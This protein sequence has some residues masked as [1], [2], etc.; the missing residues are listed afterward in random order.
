M[1]ARDR[2][3]RV[4]V[5]SLSDA[6]LLMLILGTGFPGK[7]AR[8]VAEGLLSGCGGLKSLCQHYPQ[9]LCRVEGIGRARAAQVLAALELSKRA[10]QQVDRRPRLKSPEEI[11][12]HL[13]PSMSVLRKEVFH[14][15]CFNARQVLLQDARVAEGTLNACPVDPREVF[16]AALA[17][18]ASGIVL[19]HNHPSGDPEPS[20]LDLALTR[21]LV[22]GGQI[23][24]IRVLDHLIL[25]D[26]AFTS[27]LAR[28]QLPRPLSQPLLG[29]TARPLTRREESG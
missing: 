7:S 16:S 3:Y 11:Y 17:A 8:Q 2:L 4:G 6:E 19:A 28:G 12:R 26:G 10:H 20:I 18:H 23:L 1:E 9:E 25:G 22:E 21:Q 13:A 14:V 15:L 5:A 29:R 27:M 24:G